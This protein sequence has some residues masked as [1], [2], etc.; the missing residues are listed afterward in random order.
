MIDKMI[1]SCCE[2][3]KSHWSLLLDTVTLTETIFNLC[4][5]ILQF[6]GLVL[7]DLFALLRNLS[8]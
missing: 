7:Y 2:T 5:V 3:D 6:C 8:L 4:L 1:A